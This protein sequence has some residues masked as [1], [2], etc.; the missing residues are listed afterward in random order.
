MHIWKDNIK[1]DLP[2]V[3]RGG[4]DWTDLVQNRGSWKVLVNRVMNFRVA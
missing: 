3:G 1:V 2:E 4:I